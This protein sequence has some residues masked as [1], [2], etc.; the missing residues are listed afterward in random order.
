M[1]LTCP[2]CGERDHSE[3][4]YQGDAGARRPAFNNEDVAAHAAYVYDRENPSGDHREIWN[5]TGG[6]RTHIEVRRN[7]TT[8]EIHSCRDIGPFSKGG[9]S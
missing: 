6:C 2:F 4:T 1:R 5:H 3:F 9:A 8:H 7:V